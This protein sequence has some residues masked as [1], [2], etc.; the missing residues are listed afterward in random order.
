MTPDEFNYITGRMTTAYAPRRPAMCDIYKLANRSPLIRSCLKMWEMG[1]VTLETALI[2]AVLHLADINDRLTDD[3]VLKM[4]RNPFGATVTVPQSGV[5]ATPDGI[6]YAAQ[7]KG[8][9]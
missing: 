9:T 2:M 1:E 4:R 8:E 3:V 6:V 7:N 5:E